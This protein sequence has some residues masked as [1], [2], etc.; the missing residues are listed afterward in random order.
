LIKGAGSDCRIERRTDGSEYN[1]LRTETEESCTRARNAER[2]DSCERERTDFNTCEEHRRVYQPRSR[3]R[4]QPIRGGYE[5]Y[6]GQRRLVFHRSRPS[7]QPPY[8]SL[9]LLSDAKFSAEMCEIKYAR[10]KLIFLQR[11]K[12]EAA[13][14]W[15]LLGPRFHQCSGVTCPRRCS[16]VSVE[17]I[18]EGDVSLSLARS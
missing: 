14:R 5:A 3:N 1:A 13:F 7:M 10:M 6:P 11:T 16:G 8:P 18:L 4:A 12:I 9:E 15:L 2:K 17:G